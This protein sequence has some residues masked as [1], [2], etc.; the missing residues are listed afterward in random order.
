ML[1]IQSLD[2][3]QAVISKSVTLV[4]T[5]LNICKTNRSSSMLCSMQPSVKKKKSTVRSQHTILPKVII[6]QLQNAP[7][8]TEV[9]PLKPLLKFSFGF[10]LSLLRLRVKML[11]YLMQA[12]Q[13]LPCFVVFHHALQAVTEIIVGTFKIFWGQLFRSIALQVFSGIKTT[14]CTPSTYVHSLQ[15]KKRKS[16]EVLRLRAVQYFLPA[17]TVRSWFVLANI[18][19]CN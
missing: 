16:T 19:T 4:I 6:T 5:T 12:W 1:G 8:Y 13:F 3:F 10:K 18:S 9:K 14:R 17:I 11:H 7:L 15:R 2:L